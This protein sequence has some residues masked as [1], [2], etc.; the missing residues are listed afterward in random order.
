MYTG[1]AGSPSATS[2]QNDVDQFSA[3]IFR[4]FLRASLCFP[5]SRCWCPKYPLPPASPDFIS[6]SYR[7]LILTVASISC[8][9]RFLLNIHDIPWHQQLRNPKGPYIIPGTHITFTGITNLSMT[10]SFE[11]PPPPPT[12]PGMYNQLKP[13]NFLTNFLLPTHTPFC[14]VQL[15]RARALRYISGDA[16]L[17]NRAQ[18]HSKPGGALL[19]GAVTAQAQVLHRLPETVRRDP[20]RALHE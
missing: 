18:H 7:T 14:S 19:V 10:I 1:S 13:A 6:I 5:L 3:S 17:W 9:C 8:V 20:S 16:L 4:T 2:S 15:H 11:I 12:H